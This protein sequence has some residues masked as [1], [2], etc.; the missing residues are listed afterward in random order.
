MDLLHTLLGQHTLPQLLS[1]A[2]RPLQRG[3][4]GQLD[5]NVELVAVRGGEKLLGQ[6]TRL[7]EAQQRQ[8]Q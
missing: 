3:V 4:G 5:F 6:M 8:R 1:Q 7:E 2:G